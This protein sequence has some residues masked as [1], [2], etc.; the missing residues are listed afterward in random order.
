MPR[1]RSCS[2]PR[3]A[4]TTCAG[5]ARSSRKAGVRACAAGR[6]AGLH[7]SGRGTLRLQV[8]TSRACTAACLARAC[9]IRTH[10]HTTRVRATH[11]PNHPPIR[12][13]R[14]LTR[15]RTRRCSN[16]DLSEYPATTS[17]ALLVEFFSQLP[18]PLSAH[19]SGCL[20]FHTA[21]HTSFHPRCAAGVLVGAHARILAALCAC[22]KRACAF[23]PRLRAPPLRPKKNCHHAAKKIAAVTHGHVTRDS[24]RFVLVSFMRT[25][26]HCA[27]SLVSHS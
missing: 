21:A 19:L 26:A 14:R 3:Q 8:V 15:A 24:A 12:T 6:G 2:R 23:D 1:A 4:R 7:G 18:V 11:P 16:V 22:R 25:L 9:S 17:A 20:A 10:I 5:C 27:F 13:H